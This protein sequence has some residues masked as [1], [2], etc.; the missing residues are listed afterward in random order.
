VAPQAATV[1]FGEL[2]SREARREA[3]EQMPAETSMC[4][5]GEVVL[6]SAKSLP[7]GSNCTVLP[8]CLTAGKETMRHGSLLSRSPGERVP[9]KKQRSLRWKHPC[10]CPAQAT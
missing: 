10:G 3:S 1:V 2:I 4:L 7:G 9:L 6:P 5:S 8:T